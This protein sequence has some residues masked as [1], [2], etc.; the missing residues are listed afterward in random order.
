MYLYFFHSFLASGDSCA[1]MA[2]CWRI[3]RSTSYNVIIETCNVIWQYLH[4][5]YLKHPSQEEWKTI[6]KGFYDRWDFPNCVGALDG[7]H[8]RVQCPPNSGSKYYN[9][10]GYYSVVMLATC[11]AYYAFTS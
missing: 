10:K 5:I 2:R 3:G 1:S 7:K 11:D 8:I 9:Y 6:E 4:P